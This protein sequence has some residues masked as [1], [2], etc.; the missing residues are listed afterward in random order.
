MN[1]ILGLLILFALS[2]P[3]LSLSKGI[4]NADI[5]ITPESSY[6]VFQVMRDAKK[7]FRKGKVQEA[8]PLFIQTL[9]KALKNNPHKNIDQFDYLYAHYGILSA[10]KNDEK[11]KKT[12]KTLAKKILT[13]LDKATIKGIWEEGELG[14]MQMLVY[15]RVGNQLASLL[16]KE[17][18]REDKKKLQEA[19]R[20]IKKSEDYIR[21]DN[22]MYI[23]ETQEKITNAIEGKPP[24]SGE[25][26]LLKTEKEDENQTKS[27]KI[28]QKR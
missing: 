9:K 12:Y 8:A 28:P 26:A 25:K 1:R 23:K 24:L 14:Q 3:A 13:F 6:E 16:Y 2:L 22:Q 10:L 11:Q 15:R 21:K 17:S 7:K 18:K 4:L 19:L 5:T 27:K 20:I